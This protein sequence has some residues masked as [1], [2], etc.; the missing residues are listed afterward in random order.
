MKFCVEC[1]NR[2]N[3]NEKF[4]TN[5]GTP[6]Q[7]KTTTNKQPEENQ[8]NHR[9]IRKETTSQ[10]DSDC[11][12]EEERTV[13]VKSKKPMKKRNKILLLL[14]FI[15]FLLVFG[16]YK[17]LEKYFDP[18]RDIEAMDEAIVDGDME[19]YLHYINFDE[20]AFL[21]KEA[22]FEY[23]QDEWEKEIRDSYYS[24]IKEGKDSNHLLHSTITNADEEPLYKVK[25]DNK[26]GLFTTYY[27][28]AVPLELKAM[29]NVK[30]TTLDFNGEDVA[31]DE[32]EESV[33][34]GDVYPGTQKLKAKAESEFGELT[35]EAT[36]DIS[37]SS[38][39]IFLDFPHSYLQTESNYNYED[40]I[41]YVDDEKTNFTLEES[42]SIGPFPQDATAKVYAEWEDDDGDAVLSKS[43]NVE[44]T[45]ESES[46]YFEFDES[47]AMDGDAVE[48]SNEKE[49]EVGQ[50]V[51]EFR[52]AYETAVNNA[53]YEEI[54]KFAKSGSEAEKE[55]KKFIDDMDDG[56]YNYDFKDNKV[57]D[58]EK[59]DKDFVVQTNETFDFIDDD[60]EEYHYDRVKSYD[61]EEKDGE[62]FIKEIHYDDTDKEKTD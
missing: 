52:S 24:I 19:S 17:G 28:E 43:E 26:F 45:T 4:C 33:K 44:F 54:E 40:A 21:D 56:S 12:E 20:N 25:K 18:I 55:L 41:I 38:N 23:I 62:F 22:Y 50:Y 30:N 61:I 48:D 5:C 53:D 7:K 39:E 37:Q 16:A 42:N 6:V 34:L 51:L 1:G 58:V 2:L 14:M 27:L 46:V 11:N 31:L 32:P 59:D 3:E 13:Y 10:T 47:K 9:G 36:E 35:Y 57:T 60:G 29:S 49:I 8:K 15:F